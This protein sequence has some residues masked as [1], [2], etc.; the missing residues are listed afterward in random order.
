MLCYWCSFASVFFIVKNQSPMLPPVSCFGLKRCQECGR[1]IGFVA[2]E[3]TSH[4][5]SPCDEAFRPLRQ[6]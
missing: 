3:L 6:F 2:L 4:W 1:K 5:S